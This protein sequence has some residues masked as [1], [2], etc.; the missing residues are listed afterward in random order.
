M[1]S[2]YW[3]KLYHE[4]LHDPKMGRLSD[5][6]WRRF[7]ELCL[8][9]GET[10]SDGPLPEVADMAWTLRTSPGDLETDLHLLAENGL[11]HLDGETWIVTKFA[12]RQAAVS[13][14]DR[15]RK[16]RDRQRAEEYYQTDANG[17]TNASQTIRLTETDQDTESETDQ[18]KIQRQRQTAD[19]SVAADADECLRAVRGLG[20]EEPKASELVRKGAR[21]GVLPTLADDLQAWIE[22][23]RLQDGVKKP[24]G[25]AITQVEARITPPNRAGPTGTETELAVLPY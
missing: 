20:I 13:S 18:D 22:H 9:A 24:I 2:Y 21:D 7:F 6:L 8:I 23:Y 10:E 19:Q 15:W 17:E 5:H 3:I 14:T 12:D 1:A 25:L 4:V 16:W 11:V